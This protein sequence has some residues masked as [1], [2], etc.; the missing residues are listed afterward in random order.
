MPI[1]R[2]L[3]EHHKR[4]DG[5]RFWGAAITLLLHVGAAF[6]IV[7][8]H[9]KPAE[10]V[11]MPRDFMVAKIVRLGR[12]KPKDALPT[13]VQPTAA[14]PPPRVVKLTDNDTVKPPPKTEPPPP[15]TDKNDLARALAHAKILSERNAQTDPEGDEKGD[16]DGNS[17]VASP[18]DL[19]ATAVY[20]VYHAQY[21]NPHFAA[22]MGL[23]AMARIFIDSDG[24]VL[25]AELV[26]SSGNGPFDDSVVEVLNKVKKLPPP[27][28][29]LAL[30]FA[31]SGLALEFTPS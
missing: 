25:K 6:L 17:D 8:N 30:R 2:L 9:L 11:L 13:L 5:L 16:P 7:F 10:P 15:K 1:G 19:Y 20:K 27:P 12:K 23:S 4:K 24:N 3:E 26:R 29:S 28:R 18:G 14:P 31:R 21:R 22:A